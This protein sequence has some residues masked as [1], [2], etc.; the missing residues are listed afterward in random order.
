[1]AGPVYWGHA[2]G[3][4]GAEVAIDWGDTGV[5]CTEGTLAEQLKLKW[6]QGSPRALLY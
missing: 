1:M 5:L 6:V 4:G 2:S 3:K